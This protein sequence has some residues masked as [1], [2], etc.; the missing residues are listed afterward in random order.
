LFEDVKMHLDVQEASDGRVSQLL[1]EKG[2]QDET[3]PKDF[4]G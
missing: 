1:E 4:L 3:D 2:N